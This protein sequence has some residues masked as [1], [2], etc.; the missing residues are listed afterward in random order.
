MKTSMRSL[1][2]F[3]L[4][5]WACPLVAQ[6]VKIKFVV[7]SELTTELTSLTDIH[8][9]TTHGPYNFNEISTM[10]FWGIAPDS[11]V[12][13][14]LRNNGIGV[15]LK[16]KFLKPNT[17]KSEKVWEARVKGTVTAKDSIWMKGNSFYQGTVKLRPKDVLSV[18]ESNPASREEAARAR[19]NYNASQVVGF[20]GGFLIGWP[21]GQAISS[22]Q[23]PQWGLAAGGVALLIVVGIPLSAGFKKHTEKGISIYNRKTPSGSPGLSF[24]FLPTV[25]GGT[26]VVRF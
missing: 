18:L 19:S 10:S 23:E 14:Q 9:M 17:V 3:V 6:P 20:V 26:L 25:N 4:L 15:Y 1:I 13:E 5:A 2:L 11:A 16:Y 8:V 22:K 7:Q 24:Q 12:I 21:L